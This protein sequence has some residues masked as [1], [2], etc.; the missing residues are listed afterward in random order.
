MD[1]IDI[2][3]IA[4]I[5]QRF[6]EQQGTETISHWSPTAFDELQGALHDAIMR[7]YPELDY[8]LQFRISMASRVKPDEPMQVEV[9]IL[10]LLG[11]ARVRV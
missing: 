3:R 2:G 9:A 8:T 7:E 6:L 11:Y 4:G 5:A 10:R 1:D